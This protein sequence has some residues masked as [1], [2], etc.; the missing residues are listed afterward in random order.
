[1]AKPQL[2]TRQDHEIDLLVAM[3]RFSSII[4]RPMRDGVADPAGFSSNELRILMALSGEGESAGHDLAELMGMHAMNVSRALSSLHTMGLVQAARNSKNRRRKPYRISARGA[5]AHV[6]LKPRIA[7]IASFLFG[8]LTQAERGNL[9][10][11]LGK[12]DR[13]VLAWQPAERRP[14]VPRA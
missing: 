9:R 8:V 12:L 1:M 3:L 10:R 11:I 13:Q 7:Q 2:K 4:S 5:S 6:A 14:H